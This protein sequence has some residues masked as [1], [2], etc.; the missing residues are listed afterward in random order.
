MILVG[1]SALTSVYVSLS[2]YMYWAAWSRSIGAPPHSRERFGS[3]QTW[4]ASIVPFGE[5]A[6]YRF[7]ITE[8]KS[9]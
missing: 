6:W 8:T 7:A 2:M 3:F 5:P 9:A 1:S 4:I